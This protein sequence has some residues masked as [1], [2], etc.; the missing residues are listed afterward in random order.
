MQCLRARDF[1]GRNVY[2]PLGDFP[3]QNTV[4]RE[5]LDGILHCFGSSGGS[6]I[7]APACSGKYRASPYSKDKPKFSRDVMEPAL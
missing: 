1:I 6:Q 3:A 2:Y 5:L 7:P 4:F